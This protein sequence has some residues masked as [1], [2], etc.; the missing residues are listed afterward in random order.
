MAKELD[1]ADPTPYFYDA[2]LKQIREPAGGGAAGPAAVDLAERQPGGLP[3]PPAP[4]RGPGGP[5]RQ[6][7]AGSTTTWDFSSW[8]WWRGGNRS[9]PTRR[10]TPRTGSWRT[11]TRSLPRHEIARVSELLQSQLLQPINVNPVQPSLAQ[12]NLAILEGAGPSSPSFNEFNPLFLRNRIALQASG[13]AGSQDTFGE[14]VVLSG[15]AEPVLVQPGPVP[16]P[17]PT[18][19]GRTTTRRRTSITYSRRR[20]FR[21]RRA[22]WRSTGRSTVTTGT[23][24]WI[25]LRTTSS[26]TYATRTS[27]KAD[28]SA[29]TT[30]SR[31]GPTSSAR[32]STS[33]IN[34]MRRC[35]TNSLSTWVWSLTSTLTI[36][37]PTTSW[38]SNSSRSC[39]GGGTNSSRERGTST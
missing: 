25:S 24:N 10:T 11:P 2:I 31:P 30:P 23:W 21:T 8:P 5:Q 27:T 12:N 37:P 9:T 13:V 28:G 4:G 22:S 35:R 20:A 7:G 34:T 36:R 29:F 38:T 26:R 33:R 17:R 16:L 32:W 6:P 1:P 19:S 15:L 14:E 18:A 3:V 39:A